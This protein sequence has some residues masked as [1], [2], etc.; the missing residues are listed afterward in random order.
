MCRVLCRKRVPAFS[1]HPP[2]R[3]SRTTPRMNQ[4]RGGGRGV[5]LGPPMIPAEGGPKC[6]NLNPLGN[7][8]TEAKFWLSASHIGRGGGSSFGVQRITG[9]VS[10]RSL[11]HPPLGVPPMLALACFTRK[12]WTVLFTTTD[13]GNVTGA[14]GS[15]SPNIS[16]AQ[17]LSGTLLLGGN[18]RGRWVRSYMSL[19][20]TFWQGCHLHTPAPVEVVPGTSEHISA[21]QSARPA[22]VPPPG[23]HL[24]APRMPGTR[25]SAFRCG[26]LSSVPFGMLLVVL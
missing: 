23:E 10:T 5:W 25:R 20:P 21:C 14:E 13:V 6:L 9:Q 24:F 12:I 17:H 15:G 22:V 8:G 3:Q 19:P 11:L 18:R 4:K 7:E 26:S 16:V 2:R 1:F